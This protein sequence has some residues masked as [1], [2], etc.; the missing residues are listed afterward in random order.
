MK[1]SIWIEQK[2]K[3]ES[4]NEGWKKSGAKKAQAEDNLKKGA[5][6]DKDER[7]TL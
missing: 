7:D 2:N 6:Y 3:I 5:K 4:L 1:F